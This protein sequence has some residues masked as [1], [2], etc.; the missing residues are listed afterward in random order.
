M[1][2]ANKARIREVRRSGRSWTEDGI[3]KGA[4]A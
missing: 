1:I 4:A 2:R 3:V